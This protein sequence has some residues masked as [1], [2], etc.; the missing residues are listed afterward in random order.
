MKSLKKIDKIIML[1]ENL[2]GKAVFG[3]EGAEQL[4]V[5]FIRRVNLGWQR[6]RT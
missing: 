1:S 2:K 5:S 3:S 6:I 4:G